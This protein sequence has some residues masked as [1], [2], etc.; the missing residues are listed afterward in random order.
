MN[1]MEETMSATLCG[2]ASLKILAVDDHPLTR[3]ALARVL[4]QVA[5][6]EADTL[7]AAC[8]RLV[9]D[10][11]IRLVVLDPTLP[12]A[13]GVDA[14]QPIMEASPKALVLVLA[15]RDD[16]ATAR[17]ALAAGAHGFISRRAPTRL[18]VEALRL[19][20][21]GGVYI[22]PEALHADPA[23]ARTRA[24]PPA[25]PDASAAASEKPLG[26]TPRQLDVLSHLVQG[27]PNKLI[28]RALDLREGTI[29]THI[30][31]IYRALGVVN[32]TE[33]VYAIS[34]LGVALPV[35]AP[36]P[37][38]SAAGE[39][40]RPHAAPAPVRAV[41]SRPAAIGIGWRGAVH[42]LRFA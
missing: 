23:P 15:D 17:A 26:L 21:A 22:P 8:A 16:P 7:A 19:V 37:S 4:A 34:K 33:A 14:L 20:L 2:D 3:E 38:A 35:E 32:R 41:A 6:R 11:D 30:A 13:D 24:V 25:N 36:R 1:Q 18:L 42:Q 5:P 40:L 39:P 12:D 9:A 10:P 28:C 27:K 31:A 29:K